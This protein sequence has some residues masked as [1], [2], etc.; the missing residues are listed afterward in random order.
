MAET[1]P[2]R[3]A[4]ATLHD[5]QTAYRATSYF[6]SLDGIRCLSV[7]PIIWHHSNVAP[8]PGLLG[9]GPAGVQLF[10]ALSGFLITT[11]LL[12]ERDR[13]G[14]V[15][16][17]GFYLRRSL[18]I[19]PLYYAV[20]GAVTL[21]AAFGTP[22]PEREH[23]F[24]SLPYFASYTSNWF[25]NWDV[26]HPI[27]FAYAWSLATE[28]QFYVVWPWVFV[29]SRGLSIPIVVLL[30]FLGLDAWAEHAAASADVGGGLSAL[31]SPEGVP[32][33]L[34]P[35]QAFFTT[36]VA[37][38]SSAIGLGCL[39]A[40]ALH[41][42]AGFRVFRAVFGRRW[43]APCLLLLVVLELASNRAPHFLFHAT[44]AIFVGACALR[45][46]HGLAKLLNSRVVRHVGQVSYGL[47]LLHVGVIVVLRCLEPLGVFSLAL[48]LSV[49]L[50]TLSH[51]Y[52]EEPLRRLSSIRRQTASRR[53]PSKGH[54]G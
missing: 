53:L 5:A 45:G 40:I 42:R 4:P 50:A 32:P 9:K 49:G 46:D 43:S 23:F 10:F 25:V 20:L 31:S 29:A 14:S 12:R 51:R 17:R 39:V 28:E 38:F 8:P 30:T 22:G 16:L 11:L 7:V 18:R 26:P 24:Q 33:E 2:P 41:T 47:Y 52:F 44:L 54:P 48:P 21:H 27:R 34:F 37:S 13:D 15:S 19:F 1:S 6:P 35:P 3:R 36:V